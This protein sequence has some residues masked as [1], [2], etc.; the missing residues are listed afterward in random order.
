MQLTAL[1]YIV[2]VVTD[3]FDDGASAEAAHEVRLDDRYDVDGDRYDVDGDL[4]SVERTAPSRL[5]NVLRAPTRIIEAPAPV[6]VAADADEAA[7]VAAD[8]AQV[9][10]FLPRQCVHGVEDQRP[11]LTRNEQKRTYAVLAHVV[12]RLKASDDFLKLLQLVAARESSLQQGLVH[13]LSPDLE[14][15][16]QA[17]RKTAKLYEGNPHH[18]EPE[19]WQTYGLFGMNSNYFTQVWDNQ[20]DPRVLCDAIVDILV[21][22]RAVVRV[23]KKAGAAIECTDAAGRRYQHTTRATWETVHRAVSGGKLCPSKSENVAAIMGKYFRSRAAK[24]GLDPDKSVTL[25]MLGVE[26]SKG[27]GGEI[28]ADQEAVVMGL[29]AELEAEWAEH[30]V[31]APDP[32]KIARTGS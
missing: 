26:P 11:R 13:R 17:W 21:Y 15:S 25:K 4:G 14:A 7:Q 24:F 22:R 18:A 1:A 10:Q 32:V 2:A 12:K 6:P 20:A 23:I 31:D 28:W 27:L 19:H 9:E 5:D 16:L 8:R 3:V 29:W 30:P